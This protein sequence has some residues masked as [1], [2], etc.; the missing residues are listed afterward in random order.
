M[1]TLVLS[2]LVVLG[3]TQTITGASQPSTIG[4]PDNQ[5]RAAGPRKHTGTKY[6]IILGLKPEIIKSFIFILLIK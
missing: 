4:G 1:K 5:D 3:I 2:L 6:L